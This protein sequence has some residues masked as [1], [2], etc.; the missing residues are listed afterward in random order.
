MSAALAASAT[1]GRGSISLGGA[2]GTQEAISFG[3]NASRISNT[4]TPA[5]LYVAKIVSSL[6]KLP[7]RFSC[8]L[9]GPKV[10]SEQKFRSFGVGRVAIGTG[11]SGERTSITNV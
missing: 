1:L 6:W 10:P 9:C 3:A 4:R 5:L 11:L 7:G 8:R 2:G